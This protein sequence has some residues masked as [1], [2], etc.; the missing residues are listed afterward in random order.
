M[1]AA[2]ESDQGAWK[3]RSRFCRGFELP[4]LVGRPTGTPG[5]YFDSITGVVS[6]Y[7]E[8]SPVL[9][10]SPVSAVEDSPNLG[11]SVFKL[12]SLGGTA[13]GVDLSQ[14]G[15]LFLT[16]YDLQGRLVR[17]LAAGDPLP[18]G[19]HRIKW[20]GRDR[21]GRNA[22]SGVYLVLGRSGRET[23]AV[24]VGAGALKV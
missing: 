23:S 18:A 14:G 13:V 8:S 1:T 11:T 10:M 7:H 16:V 19:T 12:R 4:E 3:T 17:E 15:D 20:D 5:W 6:V 2:D 24:R 22:A 9:I 21:Q